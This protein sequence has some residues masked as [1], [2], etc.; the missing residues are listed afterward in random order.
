[1]KK[2]LLTFT[3]VLTF[4]SFQCTYEVPTK[5]EPVDLLLGKVALKINKVKTPSEIV[6]IEA[7]LAR[8]QYDTLYRNL[9]LI[10]STSADIV[11]DDIPAGK[12]HLQVNA[13]DSAGVILYTGE[14]NV[15]V[16]AGI[17]TQVNLTLISTGKGRDILVNWE[18]NNWVDFMGNPIL[19]STSGPYDNTNISQ[20]FIIRDGN[21][22][23]M[24]YMGDIGTAKTFILYAESFDGI[25]W[26]HPLS[27]PVLYP[28]EEGSWDSWAVH[29]GPVIKEN[30]VYKMY[31][32]GFSDLW[33]HWNIGLATSTD[34]INWIKHPEPILVGNMEEFQLGANSIIKK[35]GVYY[36][37][38]TAGYFQQ[39]W[40]I[41][42][43]T[44]TDGINFT[45]YEGNPLL[46][47]SYTWEGFGVYHASVIED[48]GD[49]TMVYMGTNATAFGL[50]TSP[51]GKN[52]STISSNPF[53][54]LSN[55]Y[56]NWTDR[57]AYPNF[58]KISEIDLRIYYSAIPKNSNKYAI[59]FIM[60]M[61]FK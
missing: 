16:Q 55:T 43:A 44:S 61:N 12:W 18:S 14:T 15:N 49:Y 37:Y 59:G 50:A 57:I 4:L 28:G 27:T 29:S 23:K 34:G 2:I 35:N 31:Y 8:E 52:W 10:N 11:I 25:N 60:R 20:P 32:S 3:V 36:L 40:W 33:G 9:N 56:N 48:D 13:K 53:F 47:T 1:M 5:E 58:I 24:W 26:N 42:L 41:N 51:D 7:F 39:T 38:Y 46:T 17:L 21:L 6:L 19:Q 54:T 22:L 45:R 30:G